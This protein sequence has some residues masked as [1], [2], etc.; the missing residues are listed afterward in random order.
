[1]EDLKNKSLITRAIHGGSNVD[2]EYGAVST[3][4]YQT[5]TFAFKDAD[6]GARRFSGESSC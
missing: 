1:M 2:S 6:Q 5:S 3:P 4:I